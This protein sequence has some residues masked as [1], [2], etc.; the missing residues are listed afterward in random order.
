MEEF[1]S[2]LNAGKVALSPTAF[3]D[4]RAL[5]EK[6]NQKPP[7]V[8]EAPLEHGCSLV[9]LDPIA[10][11][12]TTELFVVPETEVLKQNEAVYRLKERD[13][14]FIIEHLVNIFYQHLPFVH[15]FSDCENRPSWRALTDCR[16][17]GQ[18]AVISDRV[19]VPPWLRTVIDV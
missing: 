11:E 13:S 16:N 17:H 18:L 15:L 9:M 4:F 8:T 12:Q 3:A 10:M 2:L 5:K 19:V 7:L 14:N 1:C 6:E